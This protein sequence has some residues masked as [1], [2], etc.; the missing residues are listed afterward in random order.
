MRPRRLVISAFGSYSGKTTVDF[1]KLGDHGLYLITGDT[2]AG[3]TAIFDALVFALYGET[4]TP[5]R[6][7]KLLRS[8]YTDGDTETSVTLDFE[9]H[10]SSYRVERNPEYIYEKVNANGTVRAIRHPSRAVLNGPDGFNVAGYNEVT[11]AVKKLT[12]LDSREFSQIVMIAQGRF[13]ELLTA[14]TDTRN[15]IFRAL[16]HTEH[17]RDLQERLRKEAID[18]KDAVRDL[19][20][21]IAKRVSAVQ[22]TEDSVHHSDLK[23]MQEK[24][25]QLNFHEAT[26]L[27]EKIVIEDEYRLDQ[28]G[29]DLIVLDERLLRIDEEIAHQKQLLQ[30]FDHL[31]KA[32]SHIPELTE[33]RDRSKAELDEMLNSPR[34]I[35]RLK[36][37]R[38]TGQESLPKFLE[39]ERLGVLS[40]EAYAEADEIEE[41]TKEVADRI[42]ILE[43]RLHDD[44]TM[45]EKVSGSDV[46]LVK[47]EESRREIRRT[48]D[49]FAS[50]QSHY[51]ELSATIHEYEDAVVRLKEDT[52]EFERI[53]EVYHAILGMYLAGQAGILAE[54]LVDG[55]PCPVC[56]STKHPRKAVKLAGVPDEDRLHDTEQQVNDAR[57]KAE[58]TARQCHSAKERIALLEKETTSLFESVGLHE[59][60]Q[61]SLDRIIANKDHMS[62][63][64][65]QEEARIAQLNEQVRT[66]NQ[67]NE[68]IPGLRS[69]LE[70]AS[71]KLEAMNDRI[72][73]LR[74]KADYEQNESKR[75]KANLPYASEHL[76]RVTITRLTKEIE[77]RELL[78]QNRRAR[79]ESD[80]KA[81]EKACAG[82]DEV[83]LAIRNSGGTTREAA[84]EKLGKSVERKEYLQDERDKRQK[85]KEEIT[86]RIGLNQPSLEEM[87]RTTA[88]LD[89]KIE[90]KG[91]IDE[92]ADVADSS[93]EGKE[94]ITLEDYVQIKYFD[95]VL[96]RANQRLHFLSDGQYFLLRSRG[97]DASVH[98]ALELNV[99]DRYT[100]KERTVRSLSGGES[101]LA[102]LALALGLSD[103]VQSRTGIE[104][105]TMFIDEGFGTLDTDAI[106]IAIRVLEKLSGENRLIGIISHVEELRQ[107]IVNQILVTKELR[108]DGKS[109][110][111]QVEI[112]RG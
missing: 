71:K 43:K 16:F 110:G 57:S 19:R 44:E 79:A 62:A 112:I 108:T 9:F 50:A 78:L 90:R 73:H 46:T 17:Y 11:E 94:K 89:G 34:T 88:E 81:L 75:L 52:A 7:A 22:S 109:S 96:D 13:Q 31:T 85:E 33:A 29:K 47:A 30:L 37:E 100:G 107:Q 64:L 48:I 51:E 18:L 20:H 45:L 58:L 93:L 2:G 83:L 38:K 3:K 69:D 24:G 84:E 70:E 111:S 56:G 105:D 76:A 92:L 68:R 67:L 42:S 6:G 49:S 60:S 8:Q 102:S 23:E 5:G 65:S 101:F 82:R 106:R 32:S 77:E 55:Y 97:G 28:K 1:S 99:L 104:I 10:G 91:W 12:G 36:E 103:E 53:S 98:E 39:I 40:K 59:L 54:Q 25:D 87:I 41:G 14:D 15:E 61:D 66:L 72:R 80:E 4:T 74:Q 95:R 27:L 26:A 35:E 86:I 63:K 21:D